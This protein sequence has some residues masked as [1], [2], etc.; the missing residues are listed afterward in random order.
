[1]DKHYLTPLF[2]PET[3]AVFAGASDQPETQIRRRALVEALTTSVT[4][5]P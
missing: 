1:M 2:Q 3:I 5:A 4:P